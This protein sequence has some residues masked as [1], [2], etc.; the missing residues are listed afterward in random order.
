MQMAHVAQ[1]SRWV[2]LTV[3]RE[4]FRMNVGVGQCS[5]VGVGVR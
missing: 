4:E 3:L 5:V 1:R 2:F